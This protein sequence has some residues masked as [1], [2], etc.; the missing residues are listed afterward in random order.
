MVADGA[1]AAAVQ[2]AAHPADRQAQQHRGSDQ[3]GQCQQRH[4]VFAHEQEHPQ[5]A[6]EEG[7]IDDQSALRQ[8]D[9]PGHER[10]RLPPSPA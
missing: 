5:H 1:E 6:A 9:H 2:Q 7:S 8:I 4:S 10:P 3:V